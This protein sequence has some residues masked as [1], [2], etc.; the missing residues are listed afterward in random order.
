VNGPTSDQVMAAQ[1]AGAPPSSRW[2]TGARPPGTCR[3]PRRTAA[4]SSRTRTTARAGWS[5]SPPR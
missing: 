2:S 5:P 1:L 3:C 4:T